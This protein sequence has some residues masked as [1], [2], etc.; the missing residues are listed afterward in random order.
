M[1]QELFV[2]KDLH[3]HLLGRPAIKAL[4]LA[5][6]VRVVGEDEKSPVAH[7]PN[8][9]TGLGKLDRKYL[10]Q[11]KEG[12]KPFALTVPCTVAIPL[13]QLVEEELER[14]EKLGVIS[15]VS[16]PTEWCA[17][18]VVVSKGHKKVRICV[19]LTQLNKSVC[20]ERYSLQAVE[21]PLAQLA[22]ARVFSTLDVITG[23]WQ[24]SLDSITDS[25]YHPFRQILL[26]TICHPHRT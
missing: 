9:F 4:D 15:R 1:E 7:Y 13:E 14:M 19:D 22:G 11:L 2:V 12:A 23:F 17:G 10:I 21:Q 5:A 8:L 6:R 20:R 26:P 16:E 24:I 3:R 25:L 18:M